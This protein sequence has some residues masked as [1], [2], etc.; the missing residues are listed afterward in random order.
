MAKNGKRTRTREKK[1]FIVVM[2]MRQ[3]MDVKGMKR[4]LVGWN[5]SK[6]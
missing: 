4:I 5:S 1:A 6:A 3:E 2:I